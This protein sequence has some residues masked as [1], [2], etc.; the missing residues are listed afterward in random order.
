VAEPLYVMRAFLFT[1]IEGSTRRWERSG[2]DMPAALAQ[3]DALLAEAIRAW[4]GKVFEHLGDGM[5]A[6]F[7]SAHAAAAAAVAAQRSLTQASWPAD[8]ELKVRMGIHAGAATRRSNNYFGATVNRSARLMNA[9]HGGQILLSEAA[10][11]GVGP[12]EPDWVLTPLGSHQLRDLTVPMKIFQLHTEGLPHDF[13]AL[14]T[15]DAYP[16]NLPRHLPTFTDRDDVLRAIGDELRDERRLI[17]IAGPAGV[18]KTR[19]AQQVA[20]EALPRHPAGVWFIDLSAVRAEDDVVVSIAA[21]TDVKIRSSERLTDAFADELGSR[22]LLLV[23]DNCEQ[24]VGGVARVVAQL[25]HVTR[26]SRFLVTSRQPLEVPGEIVHRLGGLDPSAAVELFCERATAAGGNRDISANDR[27]VGELCA[28]LDGAPLAIELAAARA[29]ALSPSEILVRLDERFHLLRSSGHRVERHQTLQ[30]A[31]GWSYQLL[32]DS[33]QLLLDRLGVFAGGF[34]LEAIEIV[35]AGDDLDRWEILDLLG[36]LVDKS[37]VVVESDGHRSRYRLLEMIA[38][39]AR[40]CLSRRGEAGAMRDRHARYF[41]QWA[42][43]IGTR[44]QGG[45]LGAGII[46]IQANID[47]LRHALDWMGERGWHKEKIELLSDL[48]VFYGTLAHR[49][50]LRRHEE[51]L[52]TSNGLEPKLRVE[53]LVGA[54]M[55]CVQSGAFRRAD[56]LLDEAAEL[57]EKLGMSWPA[58]LIHLRAMIAD[59][60]GRSSDVMRHCSTLLSSPET[61]ADVFLDLLV[62]TRMVAALVWTDPDGALD[63][64]TDALRRA[65]E[66]GS[67][68]LIAAATFTLGL[69]HLVVTKRLVLAERAFRRT[70]EVSGDVLPSASVPARIGISIRRLDSEPLE[71][72][73]VVCAAL[74]IESAGVD[75]PVSRAC[76]YDT[77]AAACA[78]LGEAGPARVLLGG[79]RRL[80]DACGFGGWAWTWSVRNRAREAL[81]SSQ[82]AAATGSPDE[83]P[84]TSE[85]DYDDVEEGL[86]T[87][88]AIQLVHMV[89]ERASP[90]TYLSEPTQVESEAKTS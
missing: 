45:D 16:S 6:A 69:V 56:G 32:C 62:R 8:C 82:S 30:Q 5:A 19:L 58:H 68:L 53:V 50:G 38:D 73:R 74:E 51:L 60:D 31:I 2:V 49:E 24:A 33:E 20:A 85:A 61:S 9:G 40:P 10:M 41:V 15:L 70:I 54:A 35:C 72:L 18:G 37:F 39:Y 13:P 12:P 77:A 17:T 1:D 78:L 7:T 23:L 64:A 43:S 26:K 52:G 4:G 14:R 87:A 89:L 59:M 21:V 22:D 83:P 66:A 57:S 71:S 47:N 36:D 29:R 11:D 84:A 44:I 80:R 76:C 34:D 81:A 67:D 75:D 25:L 79:A 42:R 90:V 46:E 3:H 48:K 65:E 55:I 28:H 86:S 27:S 88:A 63:F